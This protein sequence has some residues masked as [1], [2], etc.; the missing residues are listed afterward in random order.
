MITKSYVWSA[1]LSPTLAALVVTIPDG[2]IRAKSMLS[3]KKHL[4]WGFQG[5]PYAQPPLGDL[6]W[7]P[8]LPSQGWNGTL[9]GSLNPRMC[10]QGFPD[11]E[12][13]HDNLEPE[14][15]AMFGYEDCLLLNVYT[16]GIS[17]TVYTV[18]I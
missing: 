2:E 15:S 6:R 13:T 14:Y 4:F 7:M 3:Y 12:T 8:P 16:Q 18:L 17:K 9:D 5:I 1:L 11:P 10:L